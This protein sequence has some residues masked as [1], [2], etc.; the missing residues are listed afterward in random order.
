MGFLASVVLSAYWVVALGHGERSLSTVG[1]PAALHVPAG[2]KV[3]VSLLSPTTDLVAS[4]RRSSGDGSRLL[5]RDDA[6]AEIRHVL[7][8]TWEHHGSPIVIEGRPGTGK[9]ALLNASLKMGSDLGL[10]IGRAQGDVA[11]SS[12][13]FAVVRQVFA[14]MIG[15]MP[16]PT[17]PIDDGT[18][19]ARRVLLG[20]WNPTEDPADAYQG[21][22]H[23]L[24]TSGPGAALVGIDD[25]HLA[26]P[27]SAGW[28][29]F[30]ARRLSASSVHL[31]LTT[32]TRR[33]G[34]PDTD[35][36]VLNPSTRRFALH[37]LDLPSTSAMIAAH[38]GASISSGAA[39]AAHRVTRGNPLLIARLLTAL[40]VRRAPGT[41]PT[42]EQ[43]STS[44]SPLVAC[45]VHS[46]SST[47]PAGGTDLLEAMA[48]LGSADLR[49]AAAVAGI[50]GETAGQLADA[51]A[52]VGV[53]GW[54]RPLVFVHPFERHSV[55]AEMPRAR[56]AR[57]HANAAQILAGRGADAIEI[58]RHLMETD[59]SGDEWTAAVLIEAAR[60][61]IVAGRIESAEQLVERA[62]LEAP[63]HMLRAEVALLRAQ[64]D[65]LLGRRSAVEHLARAARM[66]PDPA[67][68][69]EVA[70]DLLDQP[71]DPSSFASILEIVRT[72]RDQLVADHPQSALRLELTESVL[73][74]AHAHRESGVTDVPL[75][76]AEL[77]EFS[78]S[79]TGL[80]LGIQRTLRNAAQLQISSQEMT[81][82]LGSLLTPDLLVGGGLVHV[83][84][85]GAALR[86]LVPRRRI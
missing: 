33:A 38:F 49:V 8:G 2:E 72:V 74:P 77:A 24:E 47:M 64:V 84:I 59:P 67:A 83:A 42:E 52:D 61:E 41:V 12:T 71:R 48:V 17:G 39:T 51:L 3:V 65:G 54:E 69:A 21:L 16:Y 73:L 26:D 9:T 4:T 10:R 62:D 43:I 63:L 50:D 15:H 32:Q 60:R 44:T 19:L 86:S 30:L 18:A 75:D 79:P 76:A 81:E 6:L 40:D 25:V 31:V 66:E 1:L 46:R 28:L 55:Y 29:Q 14:S 36:L 53:L 70:L 27:M 20:E 37:A 34:A 45:A 80:L 57:A 78:T 13:P 56:R 58:A 35:P 68:L 85:V 5:Q 82:S 11:E 23:L 22:M 7:S